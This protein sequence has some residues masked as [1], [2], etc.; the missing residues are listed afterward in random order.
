[1]RMVSHDK[2]IRFANRKLTCN[3]D[4]RSVALW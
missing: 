2:I 1:L 4:V 3:R